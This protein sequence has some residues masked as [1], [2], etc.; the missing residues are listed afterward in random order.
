MD[1]L[2]EDV[3]I[4]RDGLRGRNLQARPAG[5]PKFNLAIVMD[6]LFFGHFER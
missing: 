6:Q 3:K 1:H 5:E 2:E 4:L